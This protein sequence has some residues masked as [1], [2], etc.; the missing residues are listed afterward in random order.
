MTG[1]IR[2]PPP[3]APDRARQRPRS[4][5]VGASAASLAGRRWRGRLSAPLRTVG[6]ALQTSTISSRRTRS[7]Q[8]LRTHTLTALESCEIPPVQFLQLDEIATW[9]REVLLNPRRRHAV[10]AV[11]TDPETL[12]TRISPDE[13]AIA[14][15]GKGEVVCIETGPATFELRDALPKG[16][17]VYGGAARVWWPGLWRLSQP[18]DH[19]VFF[20]DNPRHYRASYDALVRE[21][22]GRA[23]AYES[24]LGW[25]LAQ[26]EQELVTATEEQKELREEVRSLRRQLRAA[27]DRL[28]GKGGAKLSGVD[29][30]SSETEFL[31]AVRVLYARMLDEG[32]RQ[33]HLLQKMRV[34]REFLASCCALDG[35]EPQKVVEVCAQVAA[36]IAHE[37]KGREVHQLRTGPSGGE[38]RVRFG[39]G[40][41]AWR[42]ALQLK[43]P[44]ARRLHWW[45]VPG[46]DGQ[47]VEFA[48]VGVHDD[49]SIPE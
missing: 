24:E 14:L 26:A 9:A 4:H 2:P 49:F 19:E 32:S 42:C 41:K 25:K 16:L 48:K 43:R 38:A 8:S 30:L 46:P 21:V 18:G 39:D 35:V 22:Y 20:F 28:R 40:A 17:G 36:G 27:K 47:T 31:L 33:E 23:A 34:G 11:T 45:A 29:P 5:G 15:G 3:D 7:S 44:A 10:V 1:A 12:D 6:M 37:V 13:L